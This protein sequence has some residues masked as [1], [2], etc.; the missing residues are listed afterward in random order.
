MS[1]VNR[2]YSYRKERTPRQCT[3]EQLLSIS[4]IFFPCTFFSILH[5]GL[6]LNLTINRFSQEIYLEKEK[7]NLLTKKVQQQAIS[8]TGLEGTKR[9]NFSHKHGPWS[10]FNTFWFDMGISQYYDTLWYAKE[11]RIQIGPGFFFIKHVLIERQLKAHSVAE[12]PNS[13]L[14]G[15]SKNVPSPS[16]RKASENRIK[17]RTSTKT[18]SLL[19]LKLTDTRI[20]TRVCSGIFLLLKGRI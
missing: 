19:C 10:S 16:I 12:C 15:A 18:L 9:R 13:N 5:S 8:Q 20:I 3:V 2:K 6:Y 7:L 14:N 4:R 17:K 11:I 1:N